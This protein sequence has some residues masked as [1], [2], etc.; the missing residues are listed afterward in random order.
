MAEEMLKVAPNIC[1]YVDEEHLNLTIEVAIP[2]VKKENIR[3]RMHDDSFNMTAPR[4]RNHSRCSGPG[5]CDIYRFRNQ[6][7]AAT[8]CGSD[9]DH[10]RDVRR[11]R[12]RHQ[13]WNPDRNRRRR[14]LRHAGAPRCDVHDRLCRGGSDTG[15]SGMWYLSRNDSSGS[16]AAKNIGR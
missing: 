16:S 14:L 8:R 5:R 11:P 15:R 2:G 1:S 13:V 12:R 7:A 9:T 10:G 3:L 4:F 6:T